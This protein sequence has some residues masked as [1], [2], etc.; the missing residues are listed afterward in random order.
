MGATLTVASEKGGYTLSD[1]GTYL[2]QQDDL[3]LV[4]ASEGDPALF[5]SYHVMIVNPEKHSEVNADGARAFANFI[6]SPSTQTVI[7]AFGTSEYGEPL[8]KPDAVV[9]AE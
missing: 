1:R 5:N 2:A 3:A 6:T 7:A 8:F 9:Q 4:V